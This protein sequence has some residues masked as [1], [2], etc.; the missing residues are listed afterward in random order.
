MARDGEAGLRQRAGELTSAL[1]IPDFRRL[2]AA[3]MISL[4]G[5]WAGRLALTVLVLERTGS[6][7]WAAA[8]TAVSL[9]GFVGIGQV[10]AT[11]ADRFGRV[12]VMLAADVARAALFAAM[13]LH[14]PVGA[15]LLLAFLAGL[16]SPPFEAAR[17]AALPDLVPEHRYGD[18]LAL[19]G[20]SVQSSIVVG[21][22]LGGLLLVA[23]GPRGALAINAASFLVSAVII[24]GLRSSQAAA[25][26]SDRQT[27]GGSL[28][29][30]AAN[31]FGDRMVRRALAII[32]ITG[33]LGTVDEALVVPYAAHIGMPRGLLGLLAAAVPVGTLL[34]TAVI[35]R[36]TDHHTLLRSAA[37][38]TVVTAA[39]AVPLFWLEV[40]GAGAFLAF[41]ISG[42]MF[43]VSIPTNVVIGTRL[44]RETRASAMGIAVGILMGS[45]A[46]GAAVGGLAASAVGAPRAIAGALFLASVF[47][48]WAAVTTPV[49][50]KHLAGRARVAPV[51]SR[52]ARSEPSV[53]I[54]LDAAP[55]LVDLT[56][57]E[58]ERPG[59]SQPHDHRAQF[60]RVG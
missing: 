41:V 6:P 54:D 14:L 58:S 33:A 60:V 49:D 53:V 32:S 43:A 2:W 36:S 18:A 15:L 8:V 56:A 40:G 51:P 19:S 3:D 39:L 38:C 59:L 26:A 16:A 31:L 25:P 37:L 29:A 22:A 57:L 10:L 30:A 46:A 50:A 47:G 12:S 45:Q 20:I 28:K 21:N 17:S 13:L 55:T 9:A 35:A 44:V 42:G 23:V 5:D 11:L 24:L 7:A 1:R 4:L 27:V 34:G 52:P 48:A